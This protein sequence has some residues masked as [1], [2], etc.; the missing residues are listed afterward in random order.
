MN[1]PVSKTYGFYTDLNKGAFSCY[2][3]R[4]TYDYEIK[5]TGGRIEELHK[6]SHI[7]R[8]FNDIFGRDE[9]RTA[10]YEFHRR[11]LMMATFQQLDK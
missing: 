9:V 6:I 7:A 5:T 10:F 1:D 4:K 3:C 11:I 2:L 8:F